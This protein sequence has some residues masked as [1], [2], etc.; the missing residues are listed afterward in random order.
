MEDL[1]WFVKTGGLSLASRTVIVTVVE[2]VETGMPLSVATTVKTYLSRS[3]L[4]KT[5]QINM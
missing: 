5:C 1:T 4:S 3:S 2:A